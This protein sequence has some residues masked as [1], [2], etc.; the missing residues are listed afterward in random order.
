MS[1]VCLDARFLFCGGIGTYLKNLLWHFRE[2]APSFQLIVLHDAK[3]R[4]SWLSKFDLI[5]VPSKHFTFKEQIDFFRFIPE[6]ELFW[7]PHINVPLLPI[8]AKKRLVTIHDAYHLAY[9]HTFSWFEKR[10]IKMFFSKA[11]SASMLITV[12]EFSKNELQKYT[13]ADPSKIRVIYHGAD[14]IHKKC[15][16]MPIR[17]PFL[18]Y[19]GNIK[20]HKNIHRLLQAFH[21]LKQKGFKELRLKIIGKKEGFRQL[22]HLVHQEHV[23]VLEHVKDEELPNYYAQAQ[24]LVLPSLYEGFGLTALEAM[25]AGCP[26]IV[27]RTA[28]IPEI[29]GDAS[30]YF[31]PLSEKSIAEALETVLLNEGLK[32]EL[33]EKGK[34]RSTLFSWKHSAER[35]LQ[36]LEEA[37]RL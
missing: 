24:A 4:L 19:V 16:E 3:E 32:K 13:Q 35:H 6:C 20:P 22:E 14:H 27:S 2:Y 10:M 23:D 1:R 31:D 33:R 34:S 9:L 28:S 5:C 12:S 29:C 18:L 8:R 7:S 30:Y 25:A 17:E 37:I 26:T 36:L 11:L 21:L 15:I